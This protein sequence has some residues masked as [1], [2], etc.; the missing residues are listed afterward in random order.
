MLLRYHSYINI[1]IDIYFNCELNGAS[2]SANRLSNIVK[3]GLGMSISKIE[4]VRSALIAALLLSISYS[5][6]AKAQLTNMST[7]DATTTPEAD[8]GLADIVVTAERR[9]ESLQKVGITVAA[10]Q[11][12]D[13]GALGVTKVEDVASHIPN[14]NVNY[15]LGISSFNIRGVGLSSFAA[16]LDSPIGIHVDEVYQSKPFMTGLLL[17]DI[18]RV[19]VSSGPQGTLFGR[20]T[21]GGAV[22]FYTH[23]PSD[24]LEVGG[25]LDYGN[26]DTLRGE[27]YINTPLTDTLSFRLSGFGIHQG[28]GY[29]D[30]LTLGSTEGYD[31]N[32]AVRGQLRWKAGDTD[33]LLSGHYG[34]EQGTLAPYEGVGAYTPESYARFNPNGGFGNIPLLTF[35]SAYLTG[36]P[37]GGDASCVRGND[38]KNPGDN[39]PYTS[40]NHHKHKLDN[41]SFGGMLRVDHDLGFATLTSITDYEDFV[42]DQSEVGD[43]SPTYD[44][45]WLFWHSKLQQFTQEVRLTSNGDG[46]WSY[47]IGGFYEHDKLHTRDYLTLGSGMTPAVAGFFTNTNQTTDALS[48]YT[49]HKIAV[50]DTLKLIGGFRFNH[51]RYDIDGGTCFGSGLSTGFIQRP[52][53]ATCPFLSSAEALVGGPKNKDTN[54]SFKVG[55]EWSPELNSDAINSL[56]LYGTVST[57]YRSAGYN[58][59]LA[60][61]QASFTKLSPEE[62]TAYEV[63]FKSQWANNTFRL[64]GSLFHYNFKN[65]I[66]RVDVDSLVPVTV[67]AAKINTWGAELT[68]QLQPMRG[69]QLSASGGWLDAKIDSDLTSAG[70]PIRGNSPVNSPK[71]TFNGDVN[72]KV[73]VSDGYELAFDAN[74]NWRDGQYLETSNKPAVRQR[75]YWLVNSSINFGPSNG[76]W[77]AGVWVKN[78]TKTVYRTYVNDLYNFGWLLNL[79]GP[80]RTWGGTV[81]FKY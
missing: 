23:K 3:R 48:F 43:G 55:A 13:L 63:G 49:N 60:T 56:L 52:T 72:Y 73:Q 29:Y 15:G 20:N 78:L 70:L 39:D 67:N 44:G 21:T 31:R 42:R 76:S 35:C 10:F 69:L 77:Q 4:V 14:V 64:N 51:E 71:F 26:Y 54:A 7:A 50:T 65:G 61:D 11:G 18:D 17:F 58:S 16:N 19:E 57:G 68:A 53:S 46:P 37:K 27:G 66:I 8:A 79:Y 6:V 45:T 25:K 75:P 5:S 33:V 40:N 22:N 80:P 24:T 59:D 41:E 32:Y 34:R 36:T 47:V 1:A 62:I 28:K 30:N 12:K 81:S 2:K 9:E 74:G 38:G